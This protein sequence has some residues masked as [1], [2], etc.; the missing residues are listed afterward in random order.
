MNYENND[1]SSW[2]AKSSTQCQKSSNH[3]SQDIQRDCE[4]RSP[5]VVNKDVRRRVMSK[6]P[7][8]FD[9][10]MEEVQRAQCIEWVEKSE[11]PLTFKIVLSSELARRW[12][13]KKNNKSMTY[14]KLS[15]ALR[16]YAEDKNGCLVKKVGM[17]K[18]F[19]IKLDLLQARYKGVVRQDDIAYLH[20]QL[21]KEATDTHQKSIVINEKEKQRRIIQDGYFNPSQDMCY[22]LYCH[23]KRKGV[24][25]QSRG[26]PKAQFAVPIGWRFFAL[27]PGPGFLRAYTNWH[28]A[29]H[30]TS[31]CKTSD[32]L[33]AEN[34]FI[35]NTDSTKSL[36]NWTVSFG[37]SLQ[38]DNS[39]RV[40]VTP[41][42]KYAEL[43]DFSQEFKIK[44][45]SFGEEERS[46]KII[47]QVLVEPNSYEIRSGTAN[48]LQ[49]DFDPG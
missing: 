43:D 39:D 11:Q 26:M 5:H 23:N 32:I 49:D 15:R 14:E 31:L 4:F 30:G 12:G 44:I 47:F 19:S 10:I 45:G 33:S 21:Q 17:Q 9:F 24:L 29:Y 18:C 25:Y 37:A 35:C 6:Q 3:T 46:A 1:K 13:E 16:T 36:F 2:K 27:K 7:R 8:L 34:L 20:R 41:S 42:I 48:N 40:C 38:I 28:R 22:C